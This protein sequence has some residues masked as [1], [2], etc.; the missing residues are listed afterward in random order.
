MF[1][2]TR[3]TI[4]KGWACNQMGEKRVNFARIPVYKKIISKICHQL[5]LILDFKNCKTTFIQYF[6]TYVII[7]QQDRSQLSKSNDARRRLSGDVENLRN[8]LDDM[9]S[10]V[11]KAK[12]RVGE[13]EATNQYLHDRL[14]ENNSKHVV[15]NLRAQLH[16]EV[17]EK[18]SLQNDLAL[19]KHLCD[20]LTVANI[21]LQR[22]LSILKEEMATK[23]EEWNK[24]QDINN[25]SLSTILPIE[26]EPEP[27]VEEAV[28]AVI[29]ESTQ[30]IINRLELEISQ[31]KVNLSEKDDQMNRYKIRNNESEDEIVHLKTA[32]EN[33]KWGFGSREKYL[34]TELD[35]HKSVITSLRKSFTATSETLRL[36]TE[37]LCEQLVVVDE[38]VNDDLEEEVNQFIDDQLMNATHN[39]FLDTSGDDEDQVLVL[40]GED[41]DG[42]ATNSH[43]S[44]SENSDNNNKDTNNTNNN[45]N[46]N[47]TAMDGVDGSHSQQQAVR[48]NELEELVAVLEQEMESLK[49]RESQMWKE[50]V[51]L[52]MAVERLGNTTTT[53]SASGSMTGSASGSTTGSGSG[54]LAPLTT[55]T[56]STSRS[57][58]RSSSPVNFTDSLMAAMESASNDM[59]LDADA[60]GS[61]TSLSPHVTP[62]RPSARRDAVGAVKSIRELI[63]EE[64]NG[65]SF[66]SAIEIAETETGTETVTDTV[67]MKSNYEEIHKRCNRQISLLEEE[68][69]HLKKQVE[70]Y[71]SRSVNL[72]HQIS[73]KEGIIN[74]LK[75][76][77]RTLQDDIRDVRAIEIEIRS[78]LE[79]KDTSLNKAISELTEVKNK[80]SMASAAS[81]SSSTASTSRENSINSET[82]TNSSSGSKRS[83][84]SSTSSGSGS[85]TSAHN[86]IYSAAHWRTQLFAVEESLKASQR[87]VYISQN[88][89]E[90]L[91]ATLRSMETQKNS[92][93]KDFEFSQKTVSELKSQINS[94]Q[95]TI[96][97]IEI[98]SHELNIR[99]IQLEEQNTAYKEE[100]TSAKAQIMLLTSGIR[101]LEERRSE[102]SVETFN[103]KSQHSI[104]E[105]N[106]TS[107]GDIK[108]S[109]E[110]QLQ[111]LNT[112]IS[113]LQSQN[114]ELIGIA[115]MSNKE[116]ESYKILLQNVDNKNESLS[117]E[118][119][120]SNDNLN[121][122]NNEVLV[123]T[124]RISE[125]EFNGSQSQM[126]CETLREKVTA[127]QTETKYYYEYA[128]QSEADAKSMKESMEI[129]QNEFTCKIRDLSSENNA[130]KTEV[131]E[132][133][134]VLD[135]NTQTTIDEKNQ[136]NL[137]V[138]DLYSRLR[139]NKD[140]STNTVKT[141]QD[142]VRILEH[143]NED[144]LSQLSTLQES[145]SSIESEYLLGQESISQLESQIETITLHTEDISKKYTKD[146]EELTMQLH[147][148]LT[149]VE[150]TKSDIEQQYLEK[151]RLLDET[152]LSSQQS[153]EELK[154][155][156]VTVQ[157]EKDTA[158]ENCVV[159][160]GKMSLYLDQMEQL[161]QQYD[162]VL[163]HNNTIEETKN[164]TFES[165]KTMQIQYDSDKIHWQ[166]QIQSLDVQITELVSENGSLKYTIACVEEES[167]T[168]RT[169]L[170][171]ADNNYHQQSSQC[172]SLQNY[173][174]EMKEYIEQQKTDIETLQSKLTEI[175]SNRSSISISFE[176]KQK[177]N[178]ELLEI[179]SE[180]EKREIVFETENNELNKLT[181]VLQSRIV[182][183]ESYS[184]SSYEMIEQKSM[185]IEDYHTR[186][187]RMISHQMKLNEFMQEK[188]MF[189]A[190]L[191]SKCVEI[192]LN[193]SS[194]STSNS[195]SIETEELIRSQQSEIEVLKE[196]SQRL[197]ESF[198]K[199]QMD[200]EELQ[201]RIGELEI[202]NVEGS[203]EITRLHECI[204]A[205][206]MSVVEKTD[207]SES[208]RERVSV[209]I[210]C[211]SSLE[212]SIAEKDQQIEVKDQQIESV[213][214]ELQ[215]VKEV[216]HI[217][218][219]SMQAEINELKE[220]IILLESELKA[221]E[222]QVNSISNDNENEVQTLQQCIADLE[223]R[224][225]FISKENNEIKLEIGILRE[226]I[227]DLESK[228]TVLVE[229][230]DERQYELDETRQR[231]FDLDTKLMGLEDEI[232][233]K[234]KYIEELEVKIQE[235]EE[236][237]KGIDVRTASMSMSVTQQLR[238]KDEEIA[239]L[240]LRLS[241]WE[242]REEK[243]ADA[244]TVGMLQTIHE[245]KSQVAE[246]TTLRPETAHGMNNK[247]RND[248]TK[249]IDDSADGIGGG[250]GGVDDSGASAKVVSEKNNALTEMQ[251]EL[252]EVRR[253]LFRGEGGG[254]RDDISGSI[255]G[256]GGGG[257]GGGGDYNISN[258]NQR[259]STTTRTSST[260]AVGGNGTSNSNSKALEETIAFMNEELSEALRDRDEAL[261]ENKDLV[262]RITANEST[263]EELRSLIDTLNAEKTQLQNRESKLRKEL[264]VANS[265]N[266]YKDNDG[267]NEN[268]Y[269][270]DGDRRG[271]GGEGDG[272]AAVTIS[273]LQDLLGILQTEKDDLEE[274][275]TQ[276]IERLKLQ[277]SLLKSSFEESRKENQRHIHSAMGDKTLS[278]VSFSTASKKDRDHHRARD[279]DEDEYG[280][281]YGYAEED[282]D[283]EEG[284][285]TAL[286]EYCADLEKRV[287]ALKI[288]NEDLR[289]RSLSSLTSGGTAGMNANTTDSKI[290]QW[291]C[292]LSDDL[293]VMVPD[294]T[295]Q[296][297]SK[298]Q[299]ITKRTGGR[300][301]GGDDSG[302]DSDTE[303]KMHE[304]SQLCRSLMETIQLRS[305]DVDYLNTRL[306][307]LNNVVLAYDLEKERTA[308]ELAQ[309]R[310]ERS[311]MSSYG[312]T[313]SSSSSA[314]EEKSVD[315]R[316]SRLESTLKSLNETIEKQRAESS[317]K[318]VEILHLTMEREE[319][320]WKLS[321]TH[322]EI[323]S[324]HHPT[325]SSSFNISKDKF[326]NESTMDEFERDNE[327]D[328]LTSELQEMTKKYNILTSKS[329]S[330]DK[331]HLEVTLKATKSE[332]DS[333]SN[334]YGEARV[335]VE[336]LTERLQEKDEILKKMKIE[337]KDKKVELVALMIE[338]DELEHAAANVERQNELISTLQ[339]Q[340]IELQAKVVELEEEKSNRIEEERR[341]SAMK[342][343]VESVTKELTE[344]LLSQNQELQRVQQRV[345]ELEQSEIIHIKTGSGLGMSDTDIETRKLHDTNSISSNN[346]TSNNNNIEYEDQARTSTPTTKTKRKELQRNIIDLTDRLADSEEA[347]ETSKR[348]IEA[349][350]FK[351]AL[352][353]E[354]LE[355]SRRAI[356]SNA[357]TTAA[358]VAAV[359]NKD[360][361]SMKNQNNNDMNNNTNHSHHMQQL[362]KQRD[363][364][365]AALNETQI[366]LENVQKKAT[367]E[368]IQV[369]I[370]MDTRIGDLEKNLYTV[371]QQEIQST[372]RADE[373]EEYSSS[374]R[375][376]V[377]LLQT[378]CRD[379]ENGAKELLRTAEVTESRISSL[380]ADKMRLTIALNE[381]NMKAVAGIQ[382][383]QQL[384]SVADKMMITDLE[385]KLREI[386]VD[387]DS[388]RGSVDAMTLESRRLEE[389][390]IQINEENVLL[391]ARLEELE[392]EKDNYK[393]MMMKALEDASLLSQQGPA[394]GQKTPTTS[395]LA[396]FM[397]PS[398]HRLQEQVVDLSRKNA[399][400]KS[401]EKLRPQVMELQQK[402]FTSQEELKNIQS[403]LSTENQS[404]TEQNKQLSATLHS[405][406][407]TV[408]IATMESADAKASVKEYAQRLESLGKEQQS[409]ILDLQASR[410][411]LDVMRSNAPDPK[412]VN[413]LE[414]KIDELTGENDS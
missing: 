28:D 310:Q 231:L 89:Q 15:E 170:E 402:L 255:G 262:D 200:I 357:E 297:I 187:N 346:S 302:T 393:E 327:I 329:N 369:R 32:L 206:E 36:V 134:R 57:R 29:P 82:N 289:K 331:D 363:S 122:M 157:S 412:I 281:S 144:L 64:N 242:A 116:I 83:S 376:S 174:L 66:L 34:R 53:G 204:K 249:G 145:L 154:S 68:N 325:S 133:R 54:A 78:Q 13:L 62:P 283:E 259:G 149:S 301:H 92:I 3:Y 207:E 24:E 25:I 236:E 320:N 179:I 195:T 379:L 291:L 26:L 86:D 286:V 189:I 191:E 391:K 138:Q 334:E 155:Q 132:Q 225:I 396:G 185:E 88:Q 218:E 352:I 226:C 404:L 98:N 141:L 341:Q 177:E 351:N 326:K 414:A 305:S 241:E 219:I 199:K 408:D 94:L 73:V 395:G 296:Q 2:T 202:S 17:L 65:N 407:Q 164:E 93:Q 294:H 147:S 271:S 387:R 377:N 10:T 248:A 285:N 184:I 181:G 266:I 388:W 270:H 390:S 121:I 356:V 91:S 240:R 203:Q 9:A 337:L 375:N 253:Q 272:R 110:L 45:N 340:L 394:P 131:E 373:L 127:L 109:L 194:T 159:Q 278:S 69:F 168:L 322:S 358:A 347:L 161:Q 333:L 70:E 252:V 292:E 268:E 4:K 361:N 153:I 105:E 106:I 37:E 136:M 96:K 233:E 39:P 50:N 246:L 85:N 345:Q 366:T 324:Q 307:A 150:D 312:T 224:N 378:R 290:Y 210:S 353:V 349:L 360:N 52:K 276:E 234:K 392:A 411:E 135:A 14:Q 228:E 293:K 125:L 196:Q 230:A 338:R 40:K 386:S 263:I 104:M 44:E 309:L 213:S 11:V 102:W 123:M 76:E 273:S 244:E 27:T 80:N 20:A 156:L 173:S 267:Y 193:S 223:D 87:E 409:L 171:D 74:E 383:Q 18:Q 47:N 410:K 364:L 42:G 128:Q 142:T 367:D 113:M 238:E 137:L 315:V 77:I 95:N 214:A 277:N 55:V 49:E 385:Q 192:Q 313:A 117:S 370:A 332:L 16:R 19:S 186:M 21:N 400:L 362:E 350:R 140:I 100:S 265:K 58:S 308:T 217:T 5:I 67:E 71:I 311:N 172:E 99:V 318:D 229:A 43:D 151:I 166:S 162:A 169:K 403:S 61:S 235:K 382:S 389:R 163:M 35:S 84:T 398:S 232:E 354:E 261:N 176:E 227:A 251:R 111:Q 48:I 344:K 124:N 279:H 178:D 165:L 119:Q 221:K 368:L 319:L 247:T 287:K 120:K 371:K 316:I 399:E 167:V 146:I 22:D 374:L 23:T 275:L 365:Q 1:T 237:K 75:N 372:A 205:L 343:S 114:M 381:S 257:G 8:Q 190:D 306:N 342:S 211:V 7:P 258:S 115:S 72:E 198:D 38:V 348:E 401:L 6:L 46:N 182:G 222:N 335:Q 303:S 413:E 209:L 243:D 118:L 107:L 274:E 33:L 143:T 299:L 328:R 130:F 79:K 212:E 56:N 269:D 216:S 160:N 103:L 197:Q 330:K 280:D 201:G 264:M 339:E 90:I 336:V 323:P 282:D 112:E 158:Q 148:V 220:R 108:N 129:Q 355:N 208:L 288:E 317:E 215:E 295:Q 239:H 304:L 59:D 397:N 175:E 254:S 180:L 63:D 298:L 101:A 97:E 126:E 250:G 405:F 30:L 139:E 152:I 41:G 300:D 256:I 359:V 406:R 380:E 188:D 51:D 314:G 245:L 12:L 81:S 31:M 183:L 384:P 284:T 321:T 60:G 260:E